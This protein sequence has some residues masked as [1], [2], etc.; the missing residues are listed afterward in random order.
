M[1]LS[2]RENNEEL[3]AIIERAKTLSLNDI[4]RQTKVKEISE[5]ENHPQNN[6]SHK[7]PLQKQSISSFLPNELTRISPFFVM[8]KFEMGHRPLEKRVCENSWGKME[9]QGERLSIFDEGILLAILRLSLLKKSSSFSTTI[10]QILTIL[11]TSPGRNT[12]HSVWSSIKRLG[13]TTISLYVK[14]EKKESFTHIL[15]G[16]ICDDKYNITISINRFFG[17]M[18]LKGLITNIDIDFRS[19]LKGDISKALYRFY[20]SQPANYEIHLQKLCNAINLDQSQKKFRLREKINKALNDLKMNH[21]LAAGIINEKD[22]VV[23]KKG[24]GVKV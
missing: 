18:F 22:H 15:A 20:R 4:I 11:G 7:N 8:S 13:A 14:D 19:N 2:S 10:N 12:Y 17:E 24:E 9:I 16:G 6:T 21:F 23:T 3:Y 5:K 1:T